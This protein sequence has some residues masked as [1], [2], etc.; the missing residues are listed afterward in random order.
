M[1]WH[2]LHQLAEELEGVFVKGYQKNP[3]A[4]RRI[5]DELEGVFVKCNLSRK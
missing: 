1:R 2:P 4:Q 3:T 5:A